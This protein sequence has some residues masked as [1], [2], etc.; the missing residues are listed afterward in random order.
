MLQL[1]TFQLIVSGRVQ[2]VSYRRYVIEMAQ[3]LNYVGYVQNLVN[4]DV[5]VVVNAKYE[6]D[7]EFFMSKLYDG[8]MFSHVED[9]V[10]EK[11][12]FSEFTSFTKRG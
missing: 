4:G 10:C 8:S 3:T 6:E 5:K 11:I 9:I 7:L 12:D 1:K 2:G